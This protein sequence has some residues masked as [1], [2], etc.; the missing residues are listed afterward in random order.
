MA[1]TQIT[2]GRVRF[3]YVNAFH[4][5]ADQNGVEKYSVMLLIP[6]SDTATL[7]KMKAA[8]QAAKD[9][10]VEKGK[11]LPAQLKTTLHDGDG[12]TPNGGEPYG[13]ECAG[14]YVM[15]VSSTRKPAI[16]YADK[17]PITEESELYSGCY[18]RAIINF[19]VY[20]SQGNR[21]VSAG[22]MGI[23]K[24]SDGEPLGGG[25]VRGEDWDDGFDDSADTD[26]LLG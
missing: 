15:N 9:T 11:K 20:D 16:V 17:T 2:T 14:H 19:Y 5:R 18:G 26:D 8:A 21:G 6:K 23:M 4:P 24:L 3:S 22:L 7:A 25:I 10:W 1:K 13:P 12:V